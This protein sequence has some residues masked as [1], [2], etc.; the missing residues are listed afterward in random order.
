MQYKTVSV[1]I[2]V[3]NE[4]EYISKCI[5]SLM[6]QSYPKEYYEVIIIDGMST[7]NTVSIVNDYQKQYSNIRLFTNKKMITPISFNIGIK[8]SNYD[9]II[10]LS[11]H[12]FVDKDFIKNNVK[13]LYEKGADCSGGTIETIS[14]G[15]LGESISYAMSCPFGVGNAL[16]RYSKEERLVDTVPFGAYKRSTLNKIGYFDEELARNQDDELNLRLTKAGGK[17][18][19]SPSI[20]SWYYSRSSLKKLWKQYYQYG[21]WKVRVIQKHKKPAAIRH[22]VP[23]MFILSLIFTS[24]LSFFSTVGFYIFLAIVVPYI[25]V[26]FYFSLKLS[27]KYNIKAL[28]Y[29]PIIFPILHISYGF[30]FLLGILNFYIFK[31]K[32]QVVKNTEISR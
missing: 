12:S 6:Q 28:R 30:G 24:I 19:L 17:I 21:F 25:L 27:L 5:E 13:C 20:K 29:L 8:N 31:S 3:K 18:L 10:I 23:L 32:K 7:D 2:A 26:D 4:E 16:F 22:L 9:V 15:L 1:V 14:E 11:G